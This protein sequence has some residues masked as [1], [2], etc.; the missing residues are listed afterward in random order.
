MTGL[1][2]GS[3][4]AALSLFHLLLLPYIEHVPIPKAHKH[5]HAPSRPTG[6]EG[7]FRYSVSMAIC[8]IQAGIL[9]V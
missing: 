3:L 4:L 2:P 6:A 1:H 8:D 9:Q 5:H 7:V